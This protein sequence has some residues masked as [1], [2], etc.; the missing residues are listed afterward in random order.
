MFLFQV[1]REILGTRLS[2]VTSIRGVYD[3]NTFLKAVR[4]KVAD[5]DIKFQFSLQIKV[6]GDSSDMIVVRSKADVNVC[7]DF[8]PWNQMLPHRSRPNAIPHRDTVPPVCEAKEWDEFETD[9]VP[10]LRRFYR[11]R[12]RHPIHIPDEAR[13]EMLNFLNE[14]P[15]H[16]RRR[17]G[18][19]GRPHL[20]EKMMLVQRRLRYL[21]L[22]LRII[23]VLPCGDRFCNRGSVGDVDV[24][25][26]HTKE[27]LTV[28]ALSTPPV[29]TLLY[30]QRQSLPTMRV[31]NHSQTCFLFLLGHG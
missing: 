25:V 11:G 20:K 17:S 3:F 22:M 2:G 14:G 29:A 10:S 1:C 30:P 15:R 23:P 26:S 24:V 5:K 7:V 8:G 4:P 28:T 6:S 21:G 12:F 13:M 18:I 9:I 31:H 27:Q 16:Q 19:N